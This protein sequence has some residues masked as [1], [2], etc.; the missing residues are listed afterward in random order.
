[1]K[2]LDWYHNL[3]LPEFMPPDWLFSPVWIILY[4]MIFASF[5]VAV[6][7]KS[8]V[9]KSIAMIFFTMQLFLNF[10]WSTIFFTRMDVEGALIIVIIMWIFILIT[11]VEFF[12]ISKLAAY[13][14]IP[15]FLWTT[16]ALYL[17]ATIYFLN[18]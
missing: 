4:L 1:M 9:Q 17:N 8:A 14:L 6:T 5:W 18:S 2:N 3:N 13:L 12:K 16:Y 10:I 7:A 11:I 15:Y